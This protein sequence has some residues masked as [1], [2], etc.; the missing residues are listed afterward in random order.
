MKGAGRILCLAMLTY[1]WTAAS[2]IAKEIPIEDFFKRPDFSQI[3]L[4][5]DGTHLAALAPI[6]NR[7]NVV[8]MNLATRD[9]K[10][11]TNLKKQDA[12]GLMW[13]NNERIL[14]F[15]DKD[16][17]ESFGIF[18][19]NKDGSKSRALIAPAEAQVRSGRFVVRAAQVVSR[20]EEEDDY[21]LIAYNKRNVRFFDLYRL[22]VYTGR[23]SPYEQAPG[24]QTG[25]ILDQDDK[26]RMRTLNS[27]LRVKTEYRNPETE[28]WEL[29]QDVRFDDPQ[30]VPTNIAYDGKT[31]YV[32]STIT[33][34]GEERDK[35]GVYTYDLE[36]KKLMDLVFEHP[37][38]DVGGVTFSRKTKQLAAI[39]HYYMKPGVEYFDDT[40]RE[41][42]KTLDEAF[43]DTVNTITSLTKEEDKAIIVSTSSTHPATYFLWD[44]NT[45][46][47]ESLTPDTSRPWL[48]ANDMSEMKPLTITARDGLELPAYLTL[49]KG[50][51][52]KD[53]P[54]V[55]LPHGGPWARDTWGWRPDVQFLASRGYAVLQVNFR[56]STGFGRSHVMASYREWGKAMQDDITDSVNWAVE[57][58]IVDADRVCIYG[59]SYGGYATMA[60]LTF[61]P[62]LYK[63]GINY[64]GVTSIPLLFTTAPEAWGDLAPM[65]VM[66]GDP[67]Q[68][69]EALE[70]TSPV[71]HIEAIKA[72]L[73]MAYGRQDPRVVLDHATKAE[74]ELKKYNKD[75]KLI[76]KDKEGHGFR[77]LEN[78]VEFYT[79]MENFLAE[80][81]G[82][83]PVQTSATMP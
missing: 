31:A 74:K 50:K 72:P 13:A 12:N 18:S 77:K 60:G 56:G 34:E 44:F 28:E 11:V 15:M 69:K 20:L 8:V 78:Q 62:D 71:N 36:S 54:M 22:N 46:R 43:P 3:V 80:H 52:A 19:V 7:Q 24:V 37:K 33:P 48:S 40:W 65:A 75:Y 27:G 57:E 51:E 38:A 83:K 41:R 59:G 39:G 81:I 70:A 42:Q 2:A 4:S 73:L 61:T 17:N 29:I 58:G 79:E 67:K 35:A 82:A 6:E 32:S 63:C 49:P 45:N 76:I 21:V 5:P 1:L 10:L 55:M 30:W 64:V 53:L 23:M 25:F 47:L 9:V 14:F 68:D 16:G 66:V 26:V